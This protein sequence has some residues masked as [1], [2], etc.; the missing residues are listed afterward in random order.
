MDKKSSQPD[1]PSNTPT[2]RTTLFVVVI[3]VLA[4]LFFFETSRELLG[5]TYNMNLATMSINISVVSIFAFLAP[6]VYLLGLGRLG[7]RVLALSSGII[8]AVSRVVMGVNPAVTVYLCVAVIAVISFGIFVPALVAQ[9]RQYSATSA[10]VTFVCAVAIAAG[11]DLVFRALGDTFDITVYGVTA[12]RVTALVLVLP[13]AVIFVAALLLWYRAPTE[14]TETH[15]SAPPCRALFGVGLGTLFFLYCALLGYP[16]NVARWVD[17]SYTLAVLL[18]GIALGG[19]VLALLT[20]IRTWLTSDKG[21]ITGSGLTLLA[22]VVLAYFPVPALAIVLSAAALF[23]FPVLV[24][25]IVCYLMRPGVTVKQIAA[26]MTTAAVVL[27]VLVLLFAFTLTWAFVPGMGFLRD[28]AGTIIMAAVLLSL[29]GT[30]AV[31]YRSSRSP[32]SPIPVRNLAAVCGVLVI[33]GTCS[34][35]F[36]YQ[37]HPA[38]D[39]E[40]HL[41]VMT[42]NIHQGYNTAGKINPWEILEPITRVNPDILALQESDMNRLTSTN[43]DIVQWLA[44]NLDMYI[45][46]GPETSQQIY[47]VAIL[48]KFP[49]HYTETYY[50]AS[51]EDQRVLVR[52]D[53]QWKGEPLSI[54]AVHAGLSE[55]DRTNQTAEIRDILLQNANRKVLMGDL[56]SLPTSK[57]IIHL[58]VMLNDA[59]TSSGC[60][61]MDPL[62]CT[63]SSLEPQKRIDY[64]LVSEEFAVRHCEVIRGVYGSDHLPV[65]A[66]IEIA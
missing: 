54:Y 40:D 65:W 66:E 49:L 5:A 53:I 63:S 46:F 44:H 37:S 14:P 24:H 60:P 43:V 26:F 36:I 7:T 8:L 33:I 9:F 31:R 29:L 64:I 61:P 45:Y 25:N 28:Q 13:L 15:E 17:G 3:T 48:S 52:A 12:H 32:S 59:W 6:F 16:N 57:Q 47:G 38:P 27:A 4:F 51:I 62:G 41:T 58:V 42:Y 56:N 2:G 35:V 39:G 34:S 10:P 18:F 1:I 20:S 22:F 11:A 30:F 55:E 21:L 19:F 23:F 50:L